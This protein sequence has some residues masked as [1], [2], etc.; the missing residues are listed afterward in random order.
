MY[1]HLTDRETVTWGTYGKYGNEPLRYVL[2]K[3]I[4]NDHLQNLIPFI[5]RNLNHYGIP[6]LQLMME[7]QEYRQKHN[8]RIPFVFGR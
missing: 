8:I 5:Q 6:I 7:E 4:T 1:N 2:I 3:D